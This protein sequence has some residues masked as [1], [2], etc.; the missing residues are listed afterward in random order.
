MED[1]R[2]KDERVTINKE[3][4]SFDA[5]VVLGVKQ[6][7]NTRI[8][9]PY[10]VLPGRAIVYSGG[11]VMRWYALRDGSGVAGEVRGATG[12]IQYLEIVKASAPGSLLMLRSAGCPSDVPLLQERL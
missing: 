11:E 1:K 3:F 7:L 12:A 6:A 2:R 9:G 5:G 4:E 8:F 10:A